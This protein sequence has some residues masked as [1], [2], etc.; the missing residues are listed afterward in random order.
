MTN[1]L[2][3]AERTGIRN[4][5]NL[6]FAIAH[7]YRDAD[8]VRSEFYHGR[9]VAA[10]KIAGQYNPRGDGPYTVHVHNW[11]FKDTRHH[12]GHSFMNNLKIT[13]SYAKNLICLT[14]DEAIM[15]DRNGQLVARF[16]YDASKRKAIGWRITGSPREFDIRRFDLQLRNPKGAKIG[17][18]PKCVR[19]GGTMSKVDYWYCKKCGATD[20]PT[21]V[22]MNKHDRNPSG[23][24]GERIA[25]KA[26]KEGQAAFKAGMPSNDNPYDS[27]A[28]KDSD[29]WLRYQGWKNGWTFSWFVAGQKEVRSKVSKSKTVTNPDPTLA[30]AGI[31]PKCGKKF[32]SY[33]DSVKN[34]QEYERHAKVCPKRGDHNPV[35]N[36]YKSFH[37]VDPVRQKPVYYQPPPKQLIS[38]GE[39]S[40][41]NY[42]PTRGQYVGTEFYHK[43]GDLGE[44]TIKTN[45]ILATDPEGKNLYLVRKNKDSKY[46][47]FSNRGILG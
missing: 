23:R 24:L 40:Q 33:R 45:L 39:L 35:S 19:C 21:G 4:W 36:L 14:G 18:R 7:R 25:N 42:K 1:P 31:C 44:R 10:G 34:M 46:P 32:S 37:G 38:I 13:F 5:A 43:S 47:L 3:P 16:Y 8:P 22:V 27:R 12:S 17:P 20:N 2:T 30:L 9:S 11:I 6:Q 15:L 26:H 29:E 41:I 28:V